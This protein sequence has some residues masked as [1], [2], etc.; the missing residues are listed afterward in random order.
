MTTAVED[1]TSLAPP[2]VLNSALDAPTMA[3]DRE[4]TESG[5]R[6][7][8]V[9]FSS[10][11]LEETQ[12]QQ[13]DN[14]PSETGNDN[15][16]QQ[17]HPL[18]E[19]EEGPNATENSSPLQ[20]ATSTRVLRRSTPE[21]PCGME[22]E[23]ATFGTD[24]EIGV[25]HFLE[26]RMAGSPFFQERS[27]SALPV[28]DTDEIDL[29]HLLGQGEFGRVREVEQITDKAGN[30]GIFRLLKQ[31][32]HGSSS[33][34][35]QCYSNIL[36]GSETSHLR[37]ADESNESDGEDSFC[38]DERAAMESFA[39]ETRTS[40][41]KELPEDASIEF[42]EVE[43]AKRARRVL[44]KRCWRE[45]KARYA[46]KQLKEELLVPPQEG[47]EYHMGTIGAMDL[48]ME[49]ALLARLVHPNIVRLRATAGVP[50]R[51]DY[52][53]VMDRLYTTLDHQIEEW[54]LEKPTSN[55][56]KQFLGMG[57]KWS[58]KTNLIAKK[59]HK[60]GE[61]SLDFSR[62]KLED[63][64]YKSNSRA[65]NRLIRQ[66]QLLHRLYAAFDVARALRYLHQNK[67]AYRDLKPQNIA[68]DIRGDIRI[69]DFG[70]AKELL[71]VD[72]VEFPDGYN[73]TGMTG[74]RRWMSPEVYYCENYGLSADV[75]SFGLL[76]WNLC[77]LQ[78]PFGDN[79]TLNAHHNKV[80]VKGQRPKKPRSKLISG[81][82]W[83][84][85]TMCWSTDREDRP[86]MDIICDV[87]REAI[88]SLKTDIKT[89]VGESDD[90]AAAGKNPASDPPSGAL[91]AT[92][93]TQGLESGIF[94]SRN[95]SH[96]TASTS[97]S[98]SIGTSS[99]GSFSKS[100]RGE[101]PIVKLFGNL[102]KPKLEPKEN[103][104]NVSHHPPRQE[105]EN[106]P[107]PTAVT[108]PPTRRISRLLLRG[109]NLR[110]SD[111]DARSEFLLAKSLRSLAMQTSSGHLGS[112]AGSRRGSP[113]LFGSSRSNRSSRSQQRRTLAG[114]GGDSVWSVVST[115]TT[116]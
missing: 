57:G 54:K 65:A 7:S 15:T 106:G 104:C 113:A 89:A 78:T 87:L 47:D 85:M 52:M 48:A 102:K 14:N 110:A 9:S 20:E 67:I 68:A 86:T 12:A 1:T 83:T 100:K 111:L 13:S 107:A 114:H 112:L 97:Y 30:D 8:Q 59:Q 96:A 43:Q 74:S 51:P 17:P 5:M 21:P 108:P 95:H 26:E 2:E 36:M 45:G 80:M 93:A 90:K 28:L 77:T 61:E 116:A 66:G 10:E 79:L 88:G 46:V 60:K 63:S 53:L 73:A 99:F 101:G 62:R 35:A 58:I 56:I 76:L 75:Y 72:L 31:S 69:F 109:M 6:R 49:A 84:L 16:S 64:T 94:S 32:R 18:D 24:M 3:Q 19:E 34:H 27:A 25:A 81:S 38:N 82:L 33:H 11:E 39:D 22:E 50:G 103:P 41:D 4:A 40:C 42:V 29:G 70:L 23:S 115:G 55:P 71:E 91:D 44:K 105:R 37:P 98:S 92:S